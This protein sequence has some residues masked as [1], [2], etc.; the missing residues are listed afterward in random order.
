MALGTHADSAVGLDAVEESLEGYGAV[1][2]A[3]GVAQVLPASGGW[4]QPGSS[5]YGSG[6]SE[7]TCRSTA[8]L[9]TRR[10]TL[11]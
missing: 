6:R 3:H 2:L 7:V 8:R 5:R 10:A 11:T 9:L 4:Q 1:V